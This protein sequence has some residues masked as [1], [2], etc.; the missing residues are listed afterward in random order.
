MLGLEYATEMGPG[1]QVQFNLDQS[2]V[3]N[4]HHIYKNDLFN[5]RL[6]VT[7]RKNIEGFLR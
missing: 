6:G 5:T 7:V 3:L 1:L 4:Q 2:F